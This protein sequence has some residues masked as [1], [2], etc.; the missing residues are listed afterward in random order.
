MRWRFGF[1]VSLILSMSAPGTEA[2][3]RVAAAGAIAFTVISNR[4]NSWA[5]IRVSAWIPI[6]AAP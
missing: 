1:H 2:I 4:A 6:F 3:I 5:A